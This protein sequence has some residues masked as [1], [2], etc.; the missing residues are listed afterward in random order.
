MNF[1]GIRLR[2]RWIIAVAVLVAIL[3]AVV[4]FWPNSS[5]IAVEGIE[6]YGSMNFVRRV[7]DALE[8]LRDNSPKSFAVIQQYMGRIQENSR[9]GMRAYADPPTFDFSMTSAG[10]SLTWCAGAIAHDAYHSKLYH[11]YR[12]VH[13]E[14][15][16]DDAWWGQ[17]REME[18][19]QFQL[20]V[21]YE[22]GAPDAET[23]YL[24]TLDGSHFDIDGDGRST[25]IDHWLQ[26]W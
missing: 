8:L 26:S 24:S 5:Q 25:W 1:F 12:R 2:R 21:L 16:P 23:K 14:P 7:A 4:W 9:S 3:Y 11:D 22:I 6:I 17:A 19:N 15:V 13:G 18:C 10:Y 20:H